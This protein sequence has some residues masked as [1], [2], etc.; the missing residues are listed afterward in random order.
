MPVWNLKAVYDGRSSP[1]VS[2]G[3]VLYLDAANFRSYPGTG[4][5]WFDL[6]GAGNHA[7]LYNSPTWSSTNGGTF[8]FNGTNQYAQCAAGFANFTSGLTIFSICNMGT[9]SSWERII[10]FGSGAPTDNIVLYRNSTTTTLEF[11]IINGTTTALDIQSTNG[12][13][14]STIAAYAGT[15]NGTTA[16]TYRNTTQL[17]SVAST[18]LPA[19]VTRNN[20]YIGRSNWVADA[21]FET[22]M[23]VLMIYNRGLTQAEISQNFYAFRERFNL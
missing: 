8:T 14:N 6:S 9:A 16:A 5:T 13:V 23:N 7:T 20:C 1:M 11:A 15:A 2:R 22:T 4:S 18:A 19:N 3:L 12:I 17:S 21:Y 10:D